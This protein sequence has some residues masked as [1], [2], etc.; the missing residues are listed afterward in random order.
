[1]GP[2]AQSTDVRFEVF[3]A[4]Y[5]VEIFSKR[6]SNVDNISATIRECVQMKL[7]SQ[8]LQGTASTW[9]ESLNAKH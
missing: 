5:K 8:R 2:K 6:A 3:T 9:A 1:M 4:F 7:I